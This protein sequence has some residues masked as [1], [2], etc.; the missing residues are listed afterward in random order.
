MMATFLHRSEVQLAGACQAS[1]RLGAPPYQDAG[2]I[3]GANGTP[4][5][6]ARK[7]AWS[8]A[9]STAANGVEAI[10]EGQRW[11]ADGFDKLTKTIGRVVRGTFST[12]NGEDA[13]RAADN[14]PTC[15]SLDR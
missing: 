12:S 9:M 8:V 13:I 1:P 4:R 11:L 10:W 6:L 7:V 14:P 15:Q 3:M 2:Q 5:R